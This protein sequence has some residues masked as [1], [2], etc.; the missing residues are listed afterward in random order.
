M[1]VRNEEERERLMATNKK[2]GRFKVLLFIQP[3]DKS[4]GKGKHKLC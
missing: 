3:H 4:R 1:D 2:G